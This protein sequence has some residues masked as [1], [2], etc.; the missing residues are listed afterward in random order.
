MH[1]TGL[2][3]VEV[4]SALT[5]LKERRLPNLDTDLLVARLYTGISPACKEYDG[6]V[7]GLQRELEATTDEDEKKALIERFEAVQDQTFEVATPKKKMG[8]ANLPKAFSGE[9]GEANTAANAG[10][11]IALGEEYFDFDDEPEPTE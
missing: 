10:I 6:I 1:L 4:R 3:L 8:K 11:I 7:K 2:R 9:R 5:A